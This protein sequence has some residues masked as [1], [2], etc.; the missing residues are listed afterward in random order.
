MKIGG[1]VS[2]GVAI[3]LMLAAVTSTEVSLTIRT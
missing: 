1:Y 2:Q 3:R